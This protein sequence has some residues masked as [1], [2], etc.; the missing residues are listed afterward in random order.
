MEVYR[1]ISVIIPFY[2]EEGNLEGVLKEVSD[3]LSQQ[4][5]PYEIIAI[6]DASIDQTPALLKGACERI[7]QLRTIT[8][9]RNLGQGAAFFTGFD[10]A[11]GNV[12]VT[13]DGDGQNDF[14]DVPRMLE[15]LS[16]YDAVFG[17]RS[18]R[19]DPL[20]K[21]IA[22]RIAFFFR[23]IILGDHVR[24]T[25]CGLKVMK[26]ETLNNLIPI[27]GFLRFIPFLLTQAGLACATVDVN[28][29]PRRFGKTKYSLLKGYFLPT[30]LDLIF[31]WWF[32]KNRI[33]R[34]K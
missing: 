20:P 14:R 25:A 26:K 11:E 21:L 32:K 4:N 34:I 9:S 18:H 12:V 29:R 33:H 23:R 5:V 24:D 19:N 2:N 15:L 28:H 16:R 7:P 22:S 6:D 3:V 8:H 30:I 17:Q 1:K 31:M 27:R 10:A 13:M